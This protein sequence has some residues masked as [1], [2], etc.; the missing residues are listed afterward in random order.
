MREPAAPVVAQGTAFVFLMLTGCALGLSFDLYRAACAVRRLPPSVLGAA[1]ALYALSAAGIVAAGLLLAAWGE[2]RLYAVLA[3][4][5]GTALYYLLASPAVLPAAVWTARA[6]HRAL[7]A[8]GALLAT[9]IGPLRAA[10]PAVGRVV[11]RL[12]QSATGRGARAGETARPRERR[13][14]RGWRGGRR[15]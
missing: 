13:S 1:D 10:P 14:R 12:R 6:V 8:A 15:R 5:G 2:V 7:A 9:A 3:L 11:R 4:S